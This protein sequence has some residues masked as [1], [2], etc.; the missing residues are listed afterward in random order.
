MILLLVAAYAGGSAVVGPVLG[1]RERQPLIAYAIGT[2]VL[3]VGAAPFVLS[4]MWFAELVRQRRARGKDAPARDA[5]RAVRRRVTSPDRLLGIAAV[6]LA[7]WLVMATAAAW[8]V[9]IP[10]LRPFAYDA[11]LAEWSRRLHGGRFAWEWLQPVLGHPPI[12]RAIGWLYGF[13]WGTAK[14]GV[15]LACAVAAPSHLRR[16]ILVAYV[17]EYAALGSLVATLVSSAGPVYYGAVTGASLDPFAPLVAYLR[18]LD[19]DGGFSVVLLQ[20]RL[21]SE[22]AT[23]QGFGITAFPSIHVS[24]ATLL[25]LAGQQL[26]RWWGVAGWTLCVFTLIGS[27][28]LGWHYALDGYA[29]IV[30]MVVIWWVAGRLVR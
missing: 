1:W 12:T 26:G 9:S 27:V 25:A 15:V 14:I 2:L 10:L 17:L 5:W 29:S 22:Y 11:L 19:A 8:R 7:L 3:M 28:H 18:S 21:W 4:L 23:G 6:F 30:G 13:V 20:D 24:S 16:R